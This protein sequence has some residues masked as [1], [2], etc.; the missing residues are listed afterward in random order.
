MFALK[1]YLNK[2]VKWEDDFRKAKSDEDTFIKIVKDSILE[3]V[4]SNLYKKYAFIEVAK[5][6]FL[7]FIQL[8]DEQ[9]I[10]DSSTRMR[11]EMRLHSNEEGEDN[12]GAD[13]HEETKENSKEVEEEKI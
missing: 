10:S 4:S 13:L 12:Y 2:V 1:T 3:F 6:G 7:N 9:S 8:G 5:N 11:R